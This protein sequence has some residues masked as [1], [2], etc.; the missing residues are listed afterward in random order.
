MITS[1]IG[2]GD[3]FIFDEKDNIIMK[4]FYTAGSVWDSDYHDDDFKLRSSIGLSL[5]FLSAIPISFNY[6]VPLEKEL[7]DKERFFNFQ[8]GTSF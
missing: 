3:N 2:Y 4:L 8:I 6:A 1:T 7:N 5:D